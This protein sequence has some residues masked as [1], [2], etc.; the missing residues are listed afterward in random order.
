MT[1]YIPDAAHY[2]KVL[3]L[4]EKSKAQCVDWY[5]RLLKIN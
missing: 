3:S 5:C 4:C 2:T 1:T